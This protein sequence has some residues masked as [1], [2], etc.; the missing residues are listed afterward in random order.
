MTPERRVLSGLE[1]LIT[2]LIVAST[3]ASA[4]C[5]PGVA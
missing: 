2:L 4:R 3:P 1:S 5:E